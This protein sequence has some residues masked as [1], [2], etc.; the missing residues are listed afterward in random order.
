VAVVGLIL[1]VVAGVATGAVVTSNTGAID[2][3]FWGVTISNVSIGVI[4]VAGMLTTVIGVAGLLLLMGA[5]RRGRRLRQERRVLRR[6]NQRLSQQ[7]GD[8]G[9]GPDRYVGPRTEE[10]PAQGAY[11]PSGPVAGAPVGTA[12][13]T[14]L[15]ATGQPGGGAAE[16]GRPRPADL[17]EQ[18][19]Q[20]RERLVGSARDR[21]TSDAGGG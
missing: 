12:R 13:D 20:H 7:A 6:E 21:A 1:L 19:G 5:M 10:A 8:S 17:A 16:A 2:A 9:P 15:A 18:P 14:D 4:F 3:N 11:E